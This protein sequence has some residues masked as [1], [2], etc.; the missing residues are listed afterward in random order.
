MVGTTTVRWITLGVTALWLVTW[1]SLAR[2]LDPSLDI[3]KYG[4]TVWRT[5]GAKGAVDRSETVSRARPYVER[6]TNR[7]HGQ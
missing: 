7:V 2:A 6:G 1:P 3:S 4:H 5:A